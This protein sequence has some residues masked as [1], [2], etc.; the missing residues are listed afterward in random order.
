MRKFMFIKWVVIVLFIAFIGVLV[1]AGLMPSRM[2]YYY[3]GMSTTEAR[4][5]WAE[6]N[7]IYL[8]VGGTFA[9]ITIIC[10]AVILGYIIIDGIGHLINRRIQKN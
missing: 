9:L 8:Q 10:T 5:L 7:A 1:T 6:A 3:V 4:A 2:D